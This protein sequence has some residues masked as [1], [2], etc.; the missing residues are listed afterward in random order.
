MGYRLVIGT[1]LPLAR[2]SDAEQ[3]KTLG[4]GERCRP[5]CTVAKRVHH[6]PVAVHIRAPLVHPPMVQRREKVFLQSARLV[7]FIRR[8]FLLSPPPVSVTRV[9]SDRR[10][11][12]IPRRH[13]ERRGGVAGRR[14][15]LEWSRSTRGET[16]TG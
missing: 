3:G 4:K 2:V 6:E 15:S 9:E 10:I 13:R 11:L 7:G 5:A 16:S 14:G 1:A 12:Q 8:F